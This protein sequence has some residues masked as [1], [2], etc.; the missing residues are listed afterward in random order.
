[1]PLTRRTLLGAGAAGL[2]AAALG[3]PLTRPAS[4]S[5]GVPPPP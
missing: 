2:G 5:P 1:M 3:G 4:A